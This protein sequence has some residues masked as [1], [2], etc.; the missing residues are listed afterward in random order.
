MNDG[1]LLMSK[2]TKESDGNNQSTGNIA[3]IA[4]VLDITN[5]GTGQEHEA[6]DGQDGVESIWAILLSRSESSKGIQ[7][8][9]EDNESVPQ[10]EGSMNEKTIP[11]GVGRIVLLQVVEN[12]RHRGCS[13]E[14]G[15]EGQNQ[16]SLLPQRKPNSIQDT[17]NNKVPANTVD[18]NFMRRFK[19][20]VDDEASQ[21]DVDDRPDIEDP[22][23]RCEISLVLQDN[24]WVRFRTSNGVD[25]GTQEE[26]VND[27]VCNLLQKMKARHV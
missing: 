24:L 17:G 27:H 11:P 19:P 23:S 4:L 25:S 9:D 6:E 3:F 2:D 12:K 5:S 13:E 22:W 15:N 1:V 20:L 26:E 14:D 16:M 7:N 18:S 10:R 8:S 21:K